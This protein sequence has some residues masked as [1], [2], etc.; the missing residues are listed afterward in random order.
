MNVRRAV[1]GVRM[2]RS[3]CADAGAICVC[4]DGTPGG[5]AG[6]LKSC[7]NSPPPMLVY[8]TLGSMRLTSFLSSALH[9][10][11]SRYRSLASKYA[12]SLP[13]V[14]SMNAS[15]VTCSAVTSFC[16]VSS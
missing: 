15:W 2:L 16:L 13:G 6:L 10:F 11:N 3:A 12:W 8:L 7:L 9:A 5:S 4:C 14:L 1:S